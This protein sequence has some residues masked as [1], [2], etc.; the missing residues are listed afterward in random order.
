MTLLDTNVVIDAYLPESPFHHWARQQIAFAVSGDGAGL[1]PV[2][3]AEL[4]VGRSDFSA[5]YSEL[6]A[7]GISL[8]DLS[9]K[10]SA[11]CGIAYGRYRRARQESA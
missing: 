9:F 5:L 4:V 3:L 2:S 1:N 6:Q 10:A 7:A 11:A 8:L